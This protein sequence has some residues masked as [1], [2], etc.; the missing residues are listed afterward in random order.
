MHWN[1]FHTP[2]FI[3]IDAVLA[4]LKEHGRVLVHTELYESYLKQPLK[5][6]QCPETCPPFKT[7]PALKSHL[8]S[9]HARIQPDNYTEIEK[10]P[11]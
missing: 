9:Q 10:Q 4:Q 1:S 11:S 6:H 8:E 5:C 7:L 2:F 3:S